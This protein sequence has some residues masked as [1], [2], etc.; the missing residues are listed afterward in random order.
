M[1]RLEKIQRSI[2]LLLYLYSGSI[3]NM[4]IIKKI[5]TTNKAAEMKFFKTC[6]RLYKNMLN[7]SKRVAEKLKIFDLNNIIIQYRSE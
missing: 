1:T 5:G 6:S 4:D 3:N 7:S 2:W